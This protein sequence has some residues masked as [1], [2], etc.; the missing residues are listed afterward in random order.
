MYMTGISDESEPDVPCY[1]DIWGLPQREQRC[2]ILFLASSPAKGLATICIR[3]AAVRR[4]NNTLSDDLMVLPLM[5]DH[6][7]SAFFRA[8]D[9]RHLISVRFVS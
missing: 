4:M 8:C 7:V 2:R 6:T 1:T 3:A 9:R 5:Q